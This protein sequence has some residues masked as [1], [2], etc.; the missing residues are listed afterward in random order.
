MGP[1]DCWLY[2]RTTLS[3]EMHRDWQDAGRFLNEARPDARRRA[4]MDCVERALK[5][6]EAIDWYDAN[7]PQPPAEP[8][9]LEG[10]IV[11]DAGQPR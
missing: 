8:A 11:T 1:W 2:I 6:A 9:R 4:V 7:V 5:K 10:R 3:R